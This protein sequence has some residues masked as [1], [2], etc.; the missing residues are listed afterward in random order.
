MSARK[1]R[2]ST[3]EVVVDTAKKVE[4]S[5]ENALT[6]LWDDLP[7]WQQDNHY[8]HSGYRPASNS[9]KRS[10]AS[11][12]YLHNESVNIYSHL[13]GGFSFTITGAIL[14]QVVKQRYA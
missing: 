7:S 6:V 5:I 1:R 9:F 8:I 11:L 10:F 12:G 4:K 13:M 2:P 14:Y 3:A